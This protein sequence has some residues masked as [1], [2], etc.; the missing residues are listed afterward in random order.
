MYLKKKEKGKTAN[1][2]L[3][4]PHCTASAECYRF[5]SPC[6]PEIKEISFKNYSKT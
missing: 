4:F 2:A 6:V 5:G 1:M 3:H